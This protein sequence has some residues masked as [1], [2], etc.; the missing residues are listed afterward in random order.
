MSTPSWGR[1][2]IESFTAQ[3]WAEGS[4]IIAEQFTGTAWE[5]LDF[6][7]FETE[8][9]AAVSGG[10]E[11]NAAGLFAIE[12]TDPTMSVF[13]ASQVPQGRQWVP[14][15][16]ATPMMNTFAEQVKDVTH[17]PMHPDTAHYTANWIA[18]QFAR[19]A[20]A[21]NA[22]D[23]SIPCYIVRADTPR[24]AVGFCDW[25]QK[26]YSVGAGLYDDQN[27]FL[28]VPITADMLSAPGSDASIV[29]W[30][31][32]TDQLWEFWIA[33]RNYNAGQVVGGVTPANAAAGNYA[34][35]PNIQDFGPGWVATWGGRIDN[36]SQSNGAFPGFYGVSATGIAYSSMTL[37]LAE[38]LAGVVTHAIPWGIPL[39]KNDRYSYPARRLD[40]QGSGQFDPPEGLRLRFDPRVNVDA[41]DIHPLAKLVAKGMQ[42][43]GAFIADTAGAIGIGAEGSVSFMAAGQSD[44]WVPLFGNKAYWQVFD[45]FPWS[46]F[47]FLPFNYGRAGDLFSRAPRPRRYTDTFNR[48][49]T[50]WTPGQAI[51]VEAGNARIQGN[52][53]A[54]DTWEPTYYLP[55]ATMS[56]DQF[57][58][59]D[60]AVVSA[61]KNTDHPSIRLRYSRTD[62]NVRDGY[63]F[64]YSPPLGA[65]TVRRVRNGALVTSWPA[66]E[67]TTPYVLRAEVQGPP[68]GT[69]VRLALNGI[70][71]GADFFDTAGPVDSGWVGGEFKLNNAQDDAQRVAGITYGDLLPFTRNVLRTPQP[72]A[73][74]SV[75]GIRVAWP[76]V[77]SA[78]SY[79]LYRSATPGVA[80]DTP[81][82]TLSEYQITHTDLTAPGQ[83]YYYRVVAVSQDGHPSDPS[84]EV[85]A[86]AATPPGP[87]AFTGVDGAAWPSGWT[88]ILVNG[89]TAE[90]RGNTGR[91]TQP[92]Q[93]WSGG[94]AYA[95]LTGEAAR[96]DFDVTWTLEFPTLRGVHVLGVRSTG[97]R[98]AHPATGFSV[99]LVPSINH[100]VVRASYSADRDPL[101][102]CPSIPFTFTAGGRVKVRLRASDNDIAVK[103][104]NDGTAEPNT[105]AWSGFDASVPGT[106]RIYAGIA[107]HGDG[108][109]CDLRIVSIVNN[110]A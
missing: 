97:S 28:D 78:V 90:I 24:V 43:H 55:E 89:A 102:A 101:Y 107:N 67:P 21:F 66:V 37:K 16:P 59:M 7:W 1:P 20:A 83:A 56:G 41:L 18:V 19:G 95:Y 40:G 39:A 60:V 88:T 110:T 104:W 87:N 77:P 25:Q 92:F 73:T 33:R 30:C 3:G 15:L 9:A 109:S 53:L 48:A 11:D 74:G 26:K 10:G 4:D 52:C 108:Q 82:L 8:F 35:D 81:Y 46:A 75:T 65:W 22:G 12:H 105:W 31:P 14:G 5:E 58:V 93:S 96:R 44:P 79:R 34:Y 76:S 51:Q 23:F 91:L 63:I 17:A 72:T 84:A 71:V 47:Q 42:K 80:T 49:D 70:P 94:N 13:R 45:G 32:E 68:S 29:I 99:E 27:V 106:G 57:A 103:V 64:R 62:E 98:W 85:T 100:Y 2:P 54:P 86:A 50:R 69:I 6:E 38:A 36:V 61:N